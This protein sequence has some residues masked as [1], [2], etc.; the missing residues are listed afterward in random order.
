M[1][2]QFTSSQIVQPQRNP[3]SL[4]KGDHFV[5]TDTRC[6]SQTTAREDM[7]WDG[8]VIVALELGLVAAGYVYNAVATTVKLAQA[9]LHQVPTE[10][11]LLCLTG[12]LSLSS[13]A[14][15]MTDQNR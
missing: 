10:R 11:T 5:I 3:R 12:L 13:S 9:Q 15:I 6:L 4:Q 14:G 1:D 7:Q 2:V 8:Y